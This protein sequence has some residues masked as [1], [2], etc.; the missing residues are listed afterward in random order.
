[1]FHWTSGIK[2]LKTKLK[3]NPGVKCARFA[4]KQLGLYRLTAKYKG[5]WE[6]TPPL[7]PVAI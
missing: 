5:A 7:G 4:I 3:P 6:K 2:N 1:M